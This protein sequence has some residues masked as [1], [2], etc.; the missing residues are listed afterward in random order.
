VSN[1]RR[2]KR[3][4]SSVGHGGGGRQAPFE[5]TG[6]DLARPYQERPS[7]ISVINGLHILI[8]PK[9]KDKTYAS[10]LVCLHNKHQGRA[11]SMIVLLGNNPLLGDKDLLLSN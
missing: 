3:E 5:T 1:G 2:C 11:P 8:H 10:S 4:A 9:N 6:D 7:N